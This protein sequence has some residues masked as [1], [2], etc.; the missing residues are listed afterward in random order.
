MKAQTSKY[1]YRILTVLVLLFLCFI[2]LAPF[3]VMGSYSIRTEN[4]LYDF[5]ISFI[6]KNPTWL[7]TRSFCKQWTL[8]YLDFEFSVCDRYVN[9]LV[10]YSPP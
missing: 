4:E 10:S 8:G 9:R 7:R 5:N 1:I 2:V 3:G 6:P